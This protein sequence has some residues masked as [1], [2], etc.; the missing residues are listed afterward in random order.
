MNETIEFEIMTS[1]TPQVYAVFQLV[2][3]GILRLS[4]TIFLDS[5]RVKFDIQ[6]K[7]SFT[8]RAHCIVFYVNEEGSIISDSMVIQFENVLP[9]YVSKALSKFKVW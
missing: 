5:G 7:F 6:A 2:S 3:K 9:N 8:P 1:S 4:R